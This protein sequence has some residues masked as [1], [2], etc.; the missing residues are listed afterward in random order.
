LRLEVRIARRYAKA[1]ADVLSDKK[2]EKVYEELKGISSLFDEKAIRYFKS[3]VVPA[4]RKVE[5]AKS[6]ITKIKPSKELGKV[7]MILAEKD[8][9]G[10]IKDFESEFE[11]F[12]NMRLGRLK[13]EIISAETLPEKTVETIRKKMEDLFNKKIEIETSIDPS[14]IGGFIVKVGDRVLDA[15]IKTQLENLKKQLLIK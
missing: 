2:L 11:N 10:L 3:P 6:I 14:I 4:E 9:L 7:I 5:L 15:S 12:V 8:R 1:L 13:A